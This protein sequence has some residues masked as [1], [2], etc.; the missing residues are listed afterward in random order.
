[1]KIPLHHY[2]IL[3]LLLLVG[4]SGYETQGVEPAKQSTVPSHSHI[5]TA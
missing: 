3:V 5:S 1:M 2:C 4:C